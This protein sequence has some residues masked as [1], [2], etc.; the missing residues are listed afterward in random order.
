MEKVTRQRKISNLAMRGVPIFLLSIS[1]AIPSF[2]VQEFDHTHKVYDTI[3][4]AHVSDGNV[5]YQTLSANPLALNRYLDALAA[6]SERQ[7]QG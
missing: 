1:L 6:V 7:F 3:L 5:D 4:K 2:A